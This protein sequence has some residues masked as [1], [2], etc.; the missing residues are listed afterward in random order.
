MDG[1]PSVEPLSW[2]RD[3]RS[4]GSAPQYLPNVGAFTV[5][6][7]PRSFDLKCESGGL[8]FLV[9]KI[10]RQAGPLQ[11]LRDWS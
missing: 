2:A 9:D 10:G 4:C 7:Q 11:K 3:L 1:I 5:N 8:T 6:Q